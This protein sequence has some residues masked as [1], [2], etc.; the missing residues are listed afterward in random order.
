MSCFKVIL[1]GRCFEGGIDGQAEM[2]GFYTTVGIVATTR[3]EFGQELENALHGAIKKSGLRVVNRPYQKSFCKISTV[4]SAE[5]RSSF[6]E[7][8]GVTFFNESS[9][10]SV[11]SNLTRLFLSTFQPRELVKI[12]L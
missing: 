11:F 12:R 2:V 9:L 3:Q 8:G 6:A 5:S 10:Q 4:Y 1:E 7:L